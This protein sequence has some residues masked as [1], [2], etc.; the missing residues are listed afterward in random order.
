MYMLWSVWLVWLHS[1]VIA[2]AGDVT[3]IDLF[4]IVVW[5]TVLRDGQMG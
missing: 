1:V 3:K 2:K 5:D 4:G